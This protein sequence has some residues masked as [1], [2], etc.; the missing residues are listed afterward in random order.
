MTRAF[1]LLKSI[2]KPRYI[3]LNVAVFA[4]YYL[5]STALIRLNNTPVIIFAPYA[6]PLFYAVIATGS[7]MFTIAIYSI[8][9]T[10]NNSAKY[11]SSTAGTVT[12]VGSSLFIGCGCQV[13][14]TLGI[15][16]AFI[17]SAGAIGADVF[18]ADYESWLL[19]ILLFINVALISYYTL[20]LSRPQCRIRKK[21]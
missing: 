14:V 6:K 8:R 10:R 9:N 15:F 16:S 20:K 3:I 17:G 1:A 4:V 12:A 18:I 11:L 19:L 13:P 7:I 21:G 5:F 2:Y